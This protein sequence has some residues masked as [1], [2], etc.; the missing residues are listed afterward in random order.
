MLIATC[1]AGGSHYPLQK[2]QIIFNKAIKD[3]PKPPSKSSIFLIQEFFNSK[4]KGS[5]Q[6][7]TITVFSVKLSQIS[8]RLLLLLERSFFF[9]FLLYSILVLKEGFWVNFTKKNHLL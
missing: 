5:F 4:I 8:Q 3:L 7:V 9:W 6:E 2:K 1:T